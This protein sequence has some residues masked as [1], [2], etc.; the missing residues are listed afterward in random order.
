[1]STI[2]HLKREIA[3]LKKDIENE[4]MRYE[5]LYKATLEISKDYMKYTEQYPNRHDDVFDLIN[6]DFKDIKPFDF[7]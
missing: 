7:S 5:K 3:N 2:S 4:K 1:M 6:I